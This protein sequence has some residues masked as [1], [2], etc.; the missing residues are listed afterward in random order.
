MLIQHTFHPTFLGPNS[1]FHQQQLN[2]HLPTADYLP[3]PVYGPNISHTAISRD[4]S[5]TAHLTHTFQQLISRELSRAYLLQATSSC[6]SSTCSSYSF[7][8]SSYSSFSS[9]TLYLCYI[10]SSYSS[11]SS[12]TLYLVDA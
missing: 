7:I 9:F 4:I 12:F 3:G 2:Q 11:F 1:T 8:C 10:C 5:H 6:L